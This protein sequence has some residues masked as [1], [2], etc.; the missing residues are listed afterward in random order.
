MLIDVCR[1]FGTP[2]GGHIEKGERL[3][4]SRKSVAEADSFLR[5]IILV[6]IYPRRVEHNLNSASLIGVQ[7]CVVGAGWVL[8]TVPGGEQLG[9]LASRLASAHLFDQEVI[10]WCGILDSGSC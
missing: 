10:L 3:L 1:S 9:L 8:H 4:R 5:L 2:C 7:P 6:R